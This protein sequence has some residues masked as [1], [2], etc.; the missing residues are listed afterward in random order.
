MENTIFNVYL[1]VAIAGTSGLI[2]GLI[3][4]LWRET[5]KSKEEDIL[6]PVLIGLEGTTIRDVP[7][8]AANSLNN[9]FSTFWGSQKTI[10]VTAI[11]RATILSMGITLF[12]LVL[13]R[14]YAVDSLARALED[15]FSG[16]VQSVAS[17]Y[18]LVVNAIFA[19]PSVLLTRHLVKKAAS[20]ITGYGVSKYLLL[21]AL[22]AYFFVSLNLY[23]LYIGMNSAI[24]FANA[25]L[26]G[27][28][29]IV[30]IMAQ[31]QHINAIQWPVQSSLMVD[32]VSVT[33]YA[34]LSFIPTLIFIGLISAALIGFCIT[35]ILHE[36]A[37]RTTGALALGEKTA[38]A[39]VASGLLIFSGVVAAWGKVLELVPSAN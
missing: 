5:L 21:D 12:A 19:V 4:Y 16:G 34:L 6:L 13:G 26:Q 20:S 14:A 35:K 22:A 39:S 10:C 9:F 15:V 11:I 28:I 30:K 29:E 23:L 3:A 8:A 27:A 18:F 25:D 24:A 17:L 38:L 31:F 36:L 37:L 2:S 1:I 33:I 7:H 32:G